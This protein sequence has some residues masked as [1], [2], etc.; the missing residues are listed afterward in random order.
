M[1]LVYTGCKDLL[2]HL[3]PNSGNQQ[4]VRDIIH[5]MVKGFDQELQNFVCILIALRGK[6]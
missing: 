6:F 5:T 4:Q 2:C 3:V 1:I